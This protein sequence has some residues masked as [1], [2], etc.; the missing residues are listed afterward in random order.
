[1]NGAL[2]TF[3]GAAGFGMMLA[4]TQMRSRTRLLLADMSG[5][6]VAAIHYVGVGGLA[7]AVYCFSYA[8]FDAVALKVPARHRALIM[9]AVQIAAVG[10]LLLAGLIWI[11]ALAIAGSAVAALARMQKHLRLMLAL[12]AVSTVLWGIYGLAVQSW[13]QVV[14]STVYA[15]LSVHALLRP[16]QPPE[17]H[18]V[19]P[20][21]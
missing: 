21:L 6:L 8:L 3:L 13:P 9:A 17:V 7:G 18:P 14:F 11:D 10:F 4:A 20:G 16:R 12:I 15:A 1:M 19:Q 5:N 2:I